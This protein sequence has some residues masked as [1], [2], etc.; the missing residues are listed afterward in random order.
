M[1]KLG[2]G[3]QERSICL[4]CLIRLGLRPRH[5]PLPHHQRSP[6]TIRYFTAS[7]RLWQEQADLGNTDNDQHTTRESVL[8]YHPYDKGPIRRNVEKRLHFDPDGPGGLNVTWEPTVPPSKTPDLDK[9]FRHLS[10]K[11]RLGIDSLGQPA[12][13]LILR[14]R[15]K[16][17]GRIRPDVEREYS[18]PSDESPAAAMSSSDM[19]DEMNAERGIIDTDQVCKN[20]DIAKGEWIK[21]FNLPREITGSLLATKYYGGFASK[22]YNG[23]T[24]S[25]L[26]TY[27]ERNAQMHSLDPLDL[28]NE[29][30][31]ALY[32]RSCWSAGTTDLLQIR[33]PNILNNDGIGAS[34]GRA[35]QETSEEHVSPKLSLINAILRHCWRLRPEENE[36][37]I[38]ELDI[39]LQSIHL[40]LI[41]GHGMT[42]KLLELGKYEADSHHSARHTQTNIRD[43]WCQS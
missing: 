15:H 35:F 43:I 18:E 22:L 39:Q 10:M 32:S 2:S 27:L 28:H 41:V 26:A 30:S 20:I 17:R 42:A 24:M 16:Q 23:F 21:E 8:T 38:G 11:D 19:L 34:V 25:Q 3:V 7:R 12:E 6:Q 29:F 14:E 37:S 36:T 33:A 1:Y 5:R 13:V 4:R 9:T 31:S 40:Q